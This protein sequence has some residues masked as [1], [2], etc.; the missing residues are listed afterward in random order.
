MDFHRRCDR[1]INI[2]LFVNP[3]MIQFSCKALEK[4]IPQPLHLKAKKLDVMMT[5]SFFGIA[6]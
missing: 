3:E 2:S 4:Y 6:Y 5:T 1:S